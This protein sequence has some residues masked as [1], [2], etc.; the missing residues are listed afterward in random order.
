MVEELLRWNTPAVPNRTAMEDVELGGVRIA[1]GDTVQCLLQA[2]NRD[3]DEFPNASTTDFTRTV[4]R[5]VAFS[6]GVHKCIG[7][8]LAR[9][10]LA[11]ALDEF[12]RQISD[13]RVIDSKSHIGAVWGMNSVRMSLKAR[14]TA[15]V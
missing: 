6:V 14:Q 12:H 10:I 3:E 9:V 7:A 8:A 11:S 4:N 13:Y 1:A 2:A 15:A 5:H